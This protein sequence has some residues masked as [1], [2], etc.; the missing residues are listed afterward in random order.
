M[1]LSLKCSQT[2][3]ANRP[4]RINCRL[5][6]TPRTP[7]SAA[8]HYFDDIFSHTGKPSGTE[9]HRIRRSSTTRSIGNRSSFNGSLHADGDDAGPAYSH[10]A[11]G[12][13]TE[14]E[15]KRR[16]E[17][18]LHVANYVSDQLE[19]IRSNESAA[20]Y[21]DEFEAQLDGA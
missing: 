8:A 14:E 16:K 2:L 20:V 11:A 21:E 9:R 12:A 13:D 19:R 18:D 1:T 7:S 6:Q 3:K 15:R 10:S 5:P 4:F 17:A